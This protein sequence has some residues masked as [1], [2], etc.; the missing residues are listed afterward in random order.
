MLDF[1][2]SQK[3][4]CN[5]GAAKVDD[6]TCKALTVDENGNV[7]TITTTTSDNSTLYIIVGVAIGV[8]IFVVILA[9]F[10]C[11]RR[12]QYNDQK[13]SHDNYGYKN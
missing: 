5:T 11:Y 1:D 4:V 13:Q 9:G 8:L 2:S 3:C 7:E 10:F 6:G 12:R